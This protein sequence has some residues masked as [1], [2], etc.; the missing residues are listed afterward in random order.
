M[1]AGAFADAGAQ[2]EQ[3]PANADGAQGECDATSA[4]GASSK[5]GAV[6]KP[7]REHGSKSLSP[8]EL[9]AAHQMWNAA[10]DYTIE[11]P[12]LFLT[13]SH[14]PLLYENTATGLVCK[15]FGAN[16]LPSLCESWKG[17]YR[18]PK[19][20]SL[21]WLVLGEA[22]FVRGEPQRP[23][24]AEMHAAFLQRCDETQGAILRTLAQ[25]DLAT[26]TYDQLSALI[27]TLADERYGFDGHIITTPQ[28]TLHLGVG[29]APRFAARKQREVGAPLP[30][31]ARERT[32][33]QVARP[34]NALSRLR[35]ERQ[36]KREDAS[37]REIMA[38]YGPSL[39]SEEQQQGLEQLL[40]T[41]NHAECKLWIADGAAPQGSP[42]TQ[43]GKRILGAA[44]E[45]IALSQELFQ[46]NRRLFE[47]AATNLATALQD[48]LRAS[49]T[50]TH[51]GLPRGSFDAARAWRVDL[52]DD[53]HA[54]FRKE[55]HNRI[56]LAVC[57]LI[58]ASGSRSD[59]APDIATQTWVV[60]EGLRRAGAQVQ[61]WSFS[62]FEGHT[63]LRRFSATPADAPSP[64][65]LVNGFST[66]ASPDNATQRNAQTASS[67]SRAVASPFHT[68]A[69]P[70]SS[71]SILNYFSGGM[72]RDGLAI[73]FAGHA[74]DQCDARQKLLLVLT[75]AAPMDDIGFPSSAP[76]E[77]AKRDYI[78][79]PALEDVAREIRALRSRGIAVCALFHGED[80]ALAEGKRLYGSG[81]IA[82][83][84]GLSRLAQSAANL[85]VASTQTD[86]PLPP[87]PL[88]TSGTY[89][90]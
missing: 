8:A 72:N 58:D 16:C 67:P 86:A 87:R 76:I 69:S 51:H 6:K 63:I 44:D 39:I 7:A 36:Q 54:F 20:D 81:N 70:S 9:R 25:E 61:T 71:A 2:G 55:P 46:N 15:H 52:L 45:Q 38:C 5:S 85:I 14:E 13:P 32:G 40:C 66:P 24:L 18:A 22:A 84:H 47:E 75:D 3:T 1:N 89:A 21:A 35:E 23:A 60:S 17:D 79:K 90:E 28:A 57:L 33:K 59:H 68:A 19:L 11:P 82:H 27:S 62:S 29:I 34:R 50:I 4:A 78:G 53:A 37:I 30:Q 48:H 26:I 49:D 12:R 31:Q 80:G 83:I 10:G 77:L 41:G 74:L 42:R 43:A 88:D 64:T 56:D 73:R 65:A